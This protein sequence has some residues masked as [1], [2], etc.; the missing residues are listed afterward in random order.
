[1]SKTLLASAWTYVPWKPSNAA[2][3]AALAHQWHAVRHAMTG[4]LA[5]C[6]EGFQD[7]F[8]DLDALFGESERVQV[9][10]TRRLSLLACSRR[11]FRLV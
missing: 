7:G 4:C 5:V 8:R 6:D 10:A 3:I 9:A 11:A 2:A 1:M